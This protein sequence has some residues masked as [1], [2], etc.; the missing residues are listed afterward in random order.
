MEDLELKSGDDAFA[1]LVPRLPT[2]HGVA[3]VAVG[4]GTPENDR[5]TY[6][7]PAQCREAARWLLDRA[8]EVDPP[9]GHDALPGALLRLAADLEPVDYPDAMQIRAAAARL[10]R[11]D[12][13]RKTTRTGAIPAVMLTSDA[14]QTIYRTLFGHGQLP[15]ET[16]A[17]VQDAAHEL[18]RKVVRALRGEPDDAEHV[19]ARNTG[20]LRFGGR[21]PE[22]MTT[23]D[24]RRRF[25]TV[26]AH[27]E[28]MPT[29]GAV[30]R[31]GPA[32]AVWRLA[33]AFADQDERH[34]PVF[35]V[36]LEPVDP[37]DVPPTARCAELF[38]PVGE[39]EPG[40]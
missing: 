30:V 19:P 29:A 40:R 21:I 7:S 28:Q 13:E 9:H 3:F 31:C 12:L 39:W 15:G 25:W 18:A 11:L 24:R 6:L 26:P 27:L 16:L 38:L 1:L 10:E 4:E 36:V 37:H 17:D 5:G 33:E 2:R 34:G 8:A 32:G 14:E 20:T 22:H 35:R 23:H